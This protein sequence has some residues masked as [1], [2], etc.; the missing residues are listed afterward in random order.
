M[1]TSRFADHILKGT[2]AARP[3]ASAVPVGTIYSATDNSTVY[4]SDGSSWGT[5][6]TAAPPIATDTIWDTKGDLAV[7]TGADTAAKL[8]VGTNG[9]VLTA[10]STQTTGVKWATPAG[11]GGGAITLITTSTRA[12]DGTID[13]TSIAGSYNDLIL[14]GIVRGTDA[15]VTDTL[16]MQ[17]NADTGSNYGSQNLQGTAAAASATESNSGAQ[18]SSA[19]MP[20]AGEAA[21]YFL[22][23]E[24]LIPGYASTSW[25]KHVLIHHARGTGITTGLRFVNQRMGLWNSTAAITQI[26]FSGFS[27]ANLKTGS[28]V[29]L[30]G[31][32]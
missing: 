31:R 27:T 10:D 22:F 4:Q 21:S 3:A 26:T 25:Y 20:A 13:L 23:F 14:V 7:G 15:G 12:T 30:Y 17:F 29:R 11:G 8:V 16:K 24:M 2:F 5:W 1:A 32:T 19:T 6:L 28:T 9:Q 18:I